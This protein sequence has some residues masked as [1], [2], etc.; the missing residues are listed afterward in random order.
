MPVHYGRNDA[1]TADDWKSEPLQFPVIPPLSGNAAIPF[2]GR[3]YEGPTVRMIQDPAAVRRYPVL[4]QFDSNGPTG[5]FVP[6]RAM[7]EREYQTHDT[8]M[9]PLIKIGFEQRKTGPTTENKGE[10]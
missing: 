7:T 10:L 8:A 6:G 2:H 3:L 1:P 5:C 9:L 4:P